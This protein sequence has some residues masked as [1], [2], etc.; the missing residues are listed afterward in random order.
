MCLGTTV[1][2]CTFALSA[3]SQTGRKGAIRASVRPARV[4]KSPFLSIYLFVFTPEIDA[5]GFD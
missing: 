5:Y 4:V 1:E 3:V 2:M